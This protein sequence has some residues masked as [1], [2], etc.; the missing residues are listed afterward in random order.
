LVLQA[1]RVGSDADLEG[2]ARHRRHRR[3]RR[4]QVTTRRCYRD[5]G[6]NESKGHHEGMF[7]TSLVVTACWDW[8]AR[9]TQCD[10]ERRKLVPQLDSVMVGNWM[11]RCTAS[12]SNVSEPTQLE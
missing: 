10:G 12:S 5:V 2:Q 4:R 1:S 9:G 8:L 6:A 7:F 11:T 3:H